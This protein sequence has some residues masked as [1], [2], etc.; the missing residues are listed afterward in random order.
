MYSIL[1][2]LQASVMDHSVLIVKKE[3]SKWKQIWW[4]RRVR[5]EML[6]LYIRC[7]FGGALGV[8]VIIIGNG[9]SD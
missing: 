8:I 4:K 6:M 3:M 1:K 5:E 2:T 9:H 7:L